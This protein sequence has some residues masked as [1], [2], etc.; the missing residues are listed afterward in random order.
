MYA[1][2]PAFRVV[3][4]FVFTAGDTWRAPRSDS[5]SAAS[6]TQRK[7]ADSVVWGRSQRRSD[8][9]DWSTTAPRWRHRRK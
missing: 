4:V 3:V 7:H 6:R 1:I 5:Q 9:G 8:G 2:W